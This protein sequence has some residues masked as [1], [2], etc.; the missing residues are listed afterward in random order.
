[1]KARECGNILSPVV[2][3]YITGG[4]A[5]IIAEPAKQARPI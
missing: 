5:K 2:T 1:M 4:T 3:T